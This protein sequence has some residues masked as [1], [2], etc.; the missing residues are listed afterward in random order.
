MWP[1]SASYSRCSV[2]QNR[3]VTVR[4]TKAR[5][6]PSISHISS[7]MTLDSSVDMVIRPIFNVNVSMKVLTTIQHKS[8]CL[9]ITMVNRFVQGWSDPIQTVAFI[10]QRK[11]TVIA[12]S[13][14]GRVCVTR[15][16]KASIVPSASKRII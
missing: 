4:H 16:T 2:F 7:L 5:L 12:M 3:G 9:E 13:A 1:F 6:T 14:Q 8:C 11:N 15:D 10:V